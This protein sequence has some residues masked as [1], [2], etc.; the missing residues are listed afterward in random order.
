MG[1]MGRYQRN[2]PE[3]ARGVS[4]RPK[5]FSAAQVGCSP[6]SPKQIAAAKYT[7]VHA[8]RTFTTTFCGSRA[9]SAAMGYAAA[10]HICT[11]VD[12]GTGRSTLAAVEMNE[13][14]LKELIGEALRTLVE[15]G[16]DAA[17]LGHFATEFPD[18]A[19]ATLQPRLPQTTADLMELMEQVAQRTVD[20][21]LANATFAPNRS[22]R[23]KVNVKIL[24]R[25]SSVRID[26]QLLGRLASLMGSMKAAKT[27]VREHAAQYPEAA[28]EKQTSWLEARL[29][30]AVESGERQLAQLQAVATPGQ[31]AH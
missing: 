5:P 3:A 8:D 25:P 6:P 16:A 15:G 19:H 23:T 1:G 31:P 20:R 14:R 17:T 2:L 18:R 28:G 27:A 21:A 12:S 26:P 9:V 11:F 4:H 30:D 7:K 22:R 29:L 24:G 13:N 10:R